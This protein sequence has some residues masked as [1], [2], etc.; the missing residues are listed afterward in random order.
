LQLTALW[1]AYPSR[2]YLIGNGLQKDGFPD[3][4]DIEL[5]YSSAKDLIAKISQT[6]GSIRC[7]GHLLVYQL[8]WRWPAVYQRLQLPPKRFQQFDGTMIAENAM[9]HTPNEQAAYDRTWNMPR[10]A[11]YML[12]DIRISFYRTKGYFSAGESNYDYRQRTAEIFH[13]D[14]HACHMMKLLLPK[15]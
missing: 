15:T 2:W 8:R 11:S 6:A 9:L 3:R 1:F 5:L 12:K 10:L 13:Q 14:K 4:I 7:T